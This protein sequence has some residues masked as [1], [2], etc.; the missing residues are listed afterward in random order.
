MADDGDAK[1]DEGEKKVVHTYPL[2]RVS[3][4]VAGK[5]RNLCP[6]PFLANSD[7]EIP[8]RL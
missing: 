5:K 2:C 7:F 4:S 3:F 6:C 1:K 8:C